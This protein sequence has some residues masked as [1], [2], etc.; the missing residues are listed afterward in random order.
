[1]VSIL[2][3][4]ED[5]FFS[6]R[7]TQMNIT[8]RVQRRSWPL[9]L[10]L[11]KREGRDHRDTPIRRVYASVYPH[12]GSPIGVTSHITPL[13]T[14]EGK[15][16]GPAGVGGGATSP[17]ADPSDWMRVVEGLF[18]AKRVCK[19]DEMGRST[20]SLFTFQMVNS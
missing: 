9:P 12:I 1:M 14:G 15:G 4:R 17:R 20:Y 18:D 2:L 16:E 7:R 19:A 5:L 10:P 3:L 6:H 11:P 8:H 13:P